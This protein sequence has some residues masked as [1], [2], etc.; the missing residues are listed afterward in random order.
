[1]NSTLIKVKRSGPRGW[2][3]IAA[4]LF[5]PEA[6]ELFEEAQPPVLVPVPAPASDTEPEATTTASKPAKGK[7]E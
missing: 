5:D 1:M 6:H 4:A 7:K 3:W 2:H